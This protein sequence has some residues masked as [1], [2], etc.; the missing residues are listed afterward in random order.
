MKELRS[1]WFFVGLAL[2]IS[3][4][5]ACSGGDGKGELPDAPIGGVDATPSAVGCIDPASV[6]VSD[7]YEKHTVVNATARNAICND[8]SPAIYYVRRGAGCGAKRWLVAFEGGGSCSTIEECRIRPTKYKSSI[9]ADSTSKFAGML[10]NN[11]ALNPDFFSANTVFVNYCS[12]DYWMGTQPASAA[13]DNL[14]FRGHDIVRAVMEDLNTE[15]VTGAPVLSSADDI[16]IAGSSAGGL[17][18]LGNIDAIAAGLPGKRVRAV[19]DAGWIAD[20]KAF[21]PDGENGIST[22][23]AFD[24]AFTY[25][26][27]TPDESCA[28][29]AGG[30]AGKCGIG[31]LLFPALSVPLFVHQDLKDPVQLKQLVVGATP[32]QASAYRTMF[33]ANLRAALGSLSGVFAPDV[34]DHGIIFKDEFATRTLAGTSFRE[35]LGN[36]YF[37]RAGVKQAIAP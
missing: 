6:T 2:T 18:V 24:M 25:W 8:G 31:A 1:L 27:A 17:G 29:A 13:T 37:E 35:T 5:A 9:G 34:G 19:V 33:A 7:T 28:A 22:A 12:S 23:A 4:G 36:W 32:S 21:A 15:G 14:A 30:A 20:I 26:K 10:S 11:A 16:V 3:A